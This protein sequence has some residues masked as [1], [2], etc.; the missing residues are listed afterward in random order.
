MRTLV[1]GA[2]GLIG[3]QLF[4]NIENPVVLSRQPSEAQRRLGHVETYL[5]EPE[6][7]PAPSEA[8]RGVEA[9]FNLAASRFR[10]GAGTARKSAESAIAG[11]WARATWSLGSPRWRAG[12]V[13]W[14][15][16]PRWVTTAT[17]VMKSWMNVQR[18]VM[19]FCPRS[20]QIGNAQPWLPPSSAFAWSASALEYMRDQPPH[21]T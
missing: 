6:A 1:T 11:S 7:R 17:A 9:V 8:L 20:V 5:W 3:R 10:K 16:H 18:P 19:G 21:A 12:P 14:Y 2:T 15:R 13:Y 4:R